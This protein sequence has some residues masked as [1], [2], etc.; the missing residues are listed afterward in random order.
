MRKAALIFTV[1]CFMLPNMA[2]A[3]TGAV[4]TTGFMHGFG[5]PLWGAD[6]MLAMI[7]VGLWSAQIGGRSTWA[8]PC[9]FVG[10]MALGGILG[11]S[12]FPLPFVEEGI[13]VSIL[14]LGVLIASASKLPLACSMSIVGVFAIFHGHAHSTEMPTSIGFASYAMGF[15]LATA[16]LHSAGIGLGTLMKHANFQILSRVGGGAIALG[17]MYLSV[18]Q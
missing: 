18:A 7:A 11:F 16:M 12:G 6:H 2:S 13:W 1:I 9:T 14:L 15:S 5:H 4:G 3:H 17:G 8:L 10:L